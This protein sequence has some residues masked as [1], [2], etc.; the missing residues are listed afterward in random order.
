MGEQGVAVGAASGVHGEAPVVIQ[1]PGLLDRLRA[2]ERAACEAFVDAHYA[3]VYRFFRWL[4]ND[5]DASAD[6]TQES[7]AGF[8]TSLTRLDAARAGDLK[9]WLYGIARNRWRKRCRTE[10]RGSGPL[11]QPLDAAGETIDPAPGPEETILA[12]WAAE[13]VARAVAGLPPDYREAFVLRVFQELPYPQIAELLGIG[14]GL[15]RWRVHQ[16][17]LRLR[18]QLSPGQ[19]GEESGD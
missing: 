12:G 9:A 15:A 16:G 10:Y 7:F 8:W 4:T 18:R 6:L 13:R 14:E 1:E 5:P 2:R 17:R 3:S 11:F 19:A